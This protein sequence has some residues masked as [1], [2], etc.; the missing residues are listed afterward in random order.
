MHRQFDLYRLFLAILM[1]LVLNLTF[2]SYQTWMMQ[3]K[4]EIMA[5]ELEEQQADIRNRVAVLANFEAMYRQET[6]T[7]IQSIK[8]ALGI[9]DPTPAEA[10]PIEE[11]LETAVEDTE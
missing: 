3:S 5:F 2:V 1:A 4:V 11:E 8:D 10:E 7:D 6:R 9:V